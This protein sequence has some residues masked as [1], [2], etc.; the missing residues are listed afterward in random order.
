[1]TCGVYHIV[2]KTTGFRYVGSSTNIEARWYRHRS[3]LRKNKHHSPHL[4]NVWNA[5]GE[6]NFYFLIVE[7]CDK[8]ELISRENE[9]LS[10]LVAIKMHL[11]ARLEA[12]FGGTRKG[13]KSSEEHRRK[14]SE[15]QKGKP[16]NHKKAVW[17]EER[18]KAVSDF[19]KER[20]AKGLANAFGN[21]V[22]D[23]T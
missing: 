13:M 20:H 16:R 23:N 12:S 1:M 2:D 22:A 4:Q 3:Q 18:R 9:H 11:N 17:T 15:A 6:D 14:M 7:V 21:K 10:P 19:M 8:S 5:R